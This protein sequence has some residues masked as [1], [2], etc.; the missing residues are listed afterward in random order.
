M[1]FLWGEGW[2]GGELLK[3]VGGGGRGGGKVGGT[4]REPVK[5]LI[6]KIGYLSSDIVIS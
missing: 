4:T 6:T 1:N 2:K 3:E 5:L